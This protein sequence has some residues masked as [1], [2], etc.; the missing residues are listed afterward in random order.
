MGSIDVEIDI[1][2]R[3]PEFP[4]FTNPADIA[5][6]NEIITFRR[7]YFDNVNAFHTPFWDCILN[8]RDITHL[9]VPALRILPP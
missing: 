9:P 2:L 7:E 6:V 8:V 5:R 3:H 4:L 1:L